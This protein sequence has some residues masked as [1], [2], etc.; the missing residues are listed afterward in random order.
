MLLSDISIKEL[1]NQGKL[2]ITPEPII[3][4]ASI[5]LHLSDE[6][7]TPN[8]KVEA[9]DEYELGPKQF[10]LGA[11]L[12]KITLPDDYAGLYDGSTTLARVGITSHMGSMLVSP[13]SDGNLT[14]ELF[15]AS[16]K[17]FILKKGMRIGQL[18]II[19]LDRPSENP[20][21][22]RSRYTGESHQGLVLPKK[23]IIYKTE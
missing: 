12:E 10:I 15:N 2:I 6:F 11:T 3:K 18:L 5:R 21:T 19:K 16:D 23:D 7:A 17:P 4:S 9:K 14:L 8:G 22:K 13:G 20:Q 1:L